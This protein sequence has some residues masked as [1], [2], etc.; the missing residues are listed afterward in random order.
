MIVSGTNFGKAAEDYGTFRAGFPESIFDRL[1]EFNVGTGSISPGA[2]AEV[3]RL[4]KLLVRLVIANF[5]WLPPAGNVVEAISGQ[6]RASLHF[7]HPP[8]YS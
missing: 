8:L 7:Q 3:I 2:I 1:A 5:D 4:L 6:A